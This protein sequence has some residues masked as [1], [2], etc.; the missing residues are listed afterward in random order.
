MDFDLF[1]SS[2]RWKILEIIAT[3]PSS[4]LEISQK[5]KTSVSYVSQQLKLLEAA[6]L[7]VKEKTGLAE[8]GKPRTIFSLS[9]EILQLS[10][11]MKFHSARKIIPLTDYHKRIIKIWL[12][13][14]SDL[15]YYVEKF[16]WGIESN[17]NHIK[18]IFIDLNPLLKR[19]R[20]LVVLSEVSEIKKIQLKINSFLKETGNKLDCSIISENELKKISS[21][22]VEN[23]QSIHDPNFLLDSL[24]KTYREM[25]GGEN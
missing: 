15:H 25:K 2:P 21:K 8:K 22:S 4:P 23:I 9:D 7:V 24:I 5:L 3:N 12:L 18:G 17:L 10:V 11:L 14:N 6:N 1:F 16:Y 19:T 13:E 20:I